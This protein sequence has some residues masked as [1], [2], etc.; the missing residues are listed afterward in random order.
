MPETTVN[1]VKLHYEEAGSG[2]KTVVFSHSYLMD[3]RHFSPQ[4]QALK[5]R[6]RCLAFDHRG[7]GQSEATQGGYDMENLYADAVAFIEAQD[8]APCHFVGLSTGGFIGLRLGIRRPDLVQSLVLMDTS[9]DAEPAKALLR[10]RL[11]MLVVRLLGIRPVVGRVIQ[12]FFSKKTLGDPARAG[13][14]REWRRRLLA[15]D[16]KAMV[17][18]GQGIFGRTSVY[19]QLGQIKTPTLMVVGEDDFPTPLSRAERI[20][21]GIPGAR[22]VVIP[23]AGHLCTV[24]NPTAVNSAIEEFLAAHS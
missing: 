15:V 11:M 6:Y 1:G 17:K 16:R 7:H 12:L 3:S 10:Y 18:L 21:N 5:D 2:P 4:I 20:A 19:E 13:E 23:E 9:A 14:M 24:E 8:C 22:L